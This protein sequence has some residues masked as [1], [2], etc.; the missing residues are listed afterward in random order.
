[1]SG[2][3]H[4]IHREIMGSRVQLSRNARHSGRNRKLQMGETVK[5]IRDDV[6]K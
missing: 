1:M 6:K 2:R 3:L 5:G 4:G